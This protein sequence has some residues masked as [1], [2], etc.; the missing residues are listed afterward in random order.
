M[1]SKLI[2][3]SEIPIFRNAMEYDM[4]RPTCNYKNTTHKQPQGFVQMGLPG[5]TKLVFPGL[6]CSCGRTTN[7][8][9]LCFVALEL[10]TVLENALTR[11]LNR[12]KGHTRIGSQTTCN[13][14]C[15]RRFPQGLRAA[16]SIRVMACCAK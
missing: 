6:H 2:G 11:G 13:H 1:N 15:P 8:I 12:D 4:R 3:R 7:N 9:S 16:S 10:W 14:R 5:S